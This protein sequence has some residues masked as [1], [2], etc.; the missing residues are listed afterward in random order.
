MR[1]GRCIRQLKQLWPAGCVVAALLHASPGAAAGQA[2]G[3]LQPPVAVSNGSAV[4][5][6]DEA[7]GTQRRWGWPAGGRE[8]MGRLCGGAAGQ[9]PR[10]RQRQ[11]P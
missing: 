4:G 9:M 3:E 10:P 11:T 6:G 1:L 7:A 8:R 5:E 2:D